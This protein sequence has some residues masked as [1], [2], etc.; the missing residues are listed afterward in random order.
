MWA[1]II[2]AFVWFVV[3]AATLVVFV[4]GNLSSTALITLGFISSTL[5]FM[6]LIAVLPLWMNAHHASKL[7]AK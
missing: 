4:T 1:A 2:Y 6:G 7:R 5:I 3:I